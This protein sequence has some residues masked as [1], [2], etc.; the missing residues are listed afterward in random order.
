M[1]SEFDE[2]LLSFDD[3]EGH[4]S[5]VLED[6]GTV[7]YAYLLDGGAVV[8]DVWLY[9]VGEDPININWQN[10]SSAIPFCNPKKYCTAEV[11]PRLQPDSEVAC[12]WFANGVR[13]SIMGLL[14]AQ[15]EPGSKPGWSR[16]A[17][18]A[19]PLAKP[20]ESI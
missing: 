12:A 6:D 20:L 7:A 5:V 14:W 19:G 15:L 17:R 16:K 4:R 8:G 11:L 3:P 9:N 2:V 10:Q 13:I 18:I 1:T